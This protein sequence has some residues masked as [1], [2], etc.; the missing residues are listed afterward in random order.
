[1]CCNIVQF[2]THMTCCQV[3]TCSPF[4]LPCD[5]RLRH[6]QQFSIITQPRTNGRYSI[7]DIKR[8]FVKSCHQKHGSFED[9]GLAVSSKSL[10]VLGACR[11]HCAAFKWLEVSLFSERAC[12]TVIKGTFRR[13]CEKIHSFAMIFLIGLPSVSRISTPD[14][15]DRHVSLGTSSKRCVCTNSGHFFFSYGQSGKR[16]TSI[17]RRFRKTAKSDY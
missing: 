12:D 1:M 6:Y 2:L 4:A 10:S 3:G 9:R 13:T 17:F 8:G 14:M 16:I 15:A 5:V 7:P 11:I